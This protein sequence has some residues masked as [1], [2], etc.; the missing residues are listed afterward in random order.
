VPAHSLVYTHG[1][2][3][4]QNAPCFLPSKMYGAGKTGKF[5]FPLLTN[6]LAY[7]TIHKSAT[8]WLITRKHCKDKQAGN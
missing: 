8:K 1:C 5:S 4:C 2:T 7:G 6:G 3:F